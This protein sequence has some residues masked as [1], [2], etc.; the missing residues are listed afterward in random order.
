M[1]AKSYLDG[2]HTSCVLATAATTTA[3]VGMIVAKHT[4][5]CCIQNITT[6]KIV[7][8]ASSYPYCHEASVAG[9]TPLIEKE[10]AIV[11]TRIF[12]YNTCMQQ[13][14]NTSLCS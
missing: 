4:F 2:R 3:V 11:L 8:H 12:Y 9:T 13:V 10:E 6:T 14:V 7:I 5:L 1:S